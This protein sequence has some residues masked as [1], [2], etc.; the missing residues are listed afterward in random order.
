MGVQTLTRF[1]NR[2][3]A[4]RS[5]PCGAHAGG[6]SVRL[7]HT[8]P[9]DGR[10]R[11]FSRPAGRRQTRASS[12]LRWR[13]P[14]ARCLAGGLFPVFSHRAAY[15]LIVESEFLTR[16][17]FRTFVRSEL[18]EGFLPACGLL[19]ILFTVSFGKKRDVFNFE[20][21]RFSVCSSRFIRLPSLLSNLCPI[22][23]IF[24]LIFLLEVF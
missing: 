5:V 11:R 21:I 22:T 10:S 14:D 1:E 15:F 8:L 12:G 6:Q 17:R 13:V 2:H 16:S 9:G 24:A 23:Q 3:T 7:P 4:P 20:K 18:C 19:F